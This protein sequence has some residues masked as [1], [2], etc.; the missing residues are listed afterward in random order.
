MNDPNQTPHSLFASATS[1][2]HGQ[3]LLFALQAINFLLAGGLMLCVRY[4]THAPLW[5]AVLSGII[6]FVVAWQGYLVF[7]SANPNWWAPWD[8]GI[9]QGQPMLNAFIPSFIVFLMFCSFMPVFERARDKRM[10]IEQTHRLR[11]TT[12][13]TLTPEVRSAK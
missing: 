4:A 13:P 10:R 8:E 5:A 3:I 12:P 1:P 7:Q 9:P 11:R 6:Y 2:I